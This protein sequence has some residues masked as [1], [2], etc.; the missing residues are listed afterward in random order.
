MIREMLLELGIDYEEDMVETTPTKLDQNPIGF[1]HDIPI[2][3]S[4][5]IEEFGLPDYYGFNNYIIEET[6]AAPLV[7]DYA[8]EQEARGNVRPI[9]RYN[10]VERFIFTL[11]Q[12]V[13]QKGEVPDYVMAVCETYADK[14]PALAWNSIRKILKHY[15]FAKYY[16]RIPLIMKKL[17]LKDVFEWDGN[18]FP[19]MIQDFKMLSHTFD[20]QQ[21]NK[22]WNRTYFPSLRFIAVELLYKHGAKCNYDIP[23]IRTKRKLQLF[24]K[25]MLEFYTFCNAFT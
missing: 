2:F 13:A 12:L 1:D 17:G 4:E 19:K 5:Q 20:Q 10:R 22:K 8:M 7:M 9:H 3:T 25:Y 23:F 6:L 16:N 11:A 18:T 14:T 21:L 24:K 15:R